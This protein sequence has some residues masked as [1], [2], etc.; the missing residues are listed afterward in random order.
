[1]N[2]YLCFE[3]KV[4]KQE[5]DQAGPIKM[6]NGTIGEDDSE[7]KR[8]KGEGDVD[9][10]VEQYEKE[11]EELEMINYS[12]GLEYLDAIEQASNRKK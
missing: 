12:L 5:K 11:L 10:N 6:N 7:S 4:D 3:I 1:M 9:I 2:K 8:D